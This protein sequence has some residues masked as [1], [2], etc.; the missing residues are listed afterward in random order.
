MSVL[1]TY[2]SIVF[3]PVGMLLE[4]GSENTTGPG[5]LLTLFCAIPAMFIAVR[6]IASC[7]MPDEKR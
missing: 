1:K 4:L 5:F 2:F 6:N 3:I 7:G